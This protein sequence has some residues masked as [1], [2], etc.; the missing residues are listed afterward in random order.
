V[1]AAV[2]HRYLLFSGALSAYVV[3]FAAFVFFEVPGLGIAHFYYLPVAAMA[4]TGGPRRG[5]VAGVAA[6]ALYSLGILVNP[7]IPPAEILSASTGIRLVTYAAIGALVGWFAAH[8]GELVARLQV[9]A[10]R[11]YLTG[12]P[13]IRAFEAELGRRLALGLPFCLL[14][15]DMDRLKE[16]NDGGGHS[17]G[18]DALCRLAETLAASVRPEDEVARVG[19]DEFA[20]LTSLSSGEDAAHL[21]DRLEQ[22]LEGEGTSISFGWALFPGECGNAL[23]LFRTA[24]ERLYQ[25]KLARGQ[26]GRGGGVVSL[27][28]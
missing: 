3:V 11:D 23:A 26:A 1:F 28:P 24:D 18:N 10:E 7:D 6:D 2:S 17:A 13:N 4:M 12:L 15:G 9:L 20:L 5:V 27:L 14:L 21:C 22:L 25:R 16:I 19:G 8:N